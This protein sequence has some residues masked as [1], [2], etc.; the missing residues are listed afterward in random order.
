MQLQ[1]YTHSISD[2]FILL[3][4]SIKY[5]HVL[6]HST[7]IVFNLAYILASNWPYKLRTCVVSAFGLVQRKNQKPGVLSMQTLE[8]VQHS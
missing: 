4:H 6:I 2:M 7:R 5:H 8:W 1:S 3:T